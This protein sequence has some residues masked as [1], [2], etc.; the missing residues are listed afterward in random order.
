MHQLTFYGRHLSHNAILDCSLGG[1]WFAGV[2]LGLWAARFYGDV[3]GML[4]LDAGHFAPEFSD[5]CVASLLPLF[6]A[7]FAVFFFHRWGI[8]LSC[9]LRGLAVGFTLGAL[10]AAGGAWLCALLFFSGLLGSSAVLWFLWRR[11]RLGMADF[12]RDGAYCAAGCILLAAVDT[13][14]VG[15]FLAHALSF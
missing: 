10:A 9:G 6:F 14:V 12:W 7:A 13:W 15:P 11:L 3:F 8:F 1:S 5:A 4:A 2:T